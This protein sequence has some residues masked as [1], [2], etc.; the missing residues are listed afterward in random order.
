MIRTH[1]TSGMKVPKNLKNNYRIR[2]FFVAWEVGIGD[3]TRM[4]NVGLSVVEVFC[5]D[6]FFR[7]GIRRIVSVCEYG[8]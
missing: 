3:S 5:R 2:A 6:R 4:V 7:D 8:I 1:D